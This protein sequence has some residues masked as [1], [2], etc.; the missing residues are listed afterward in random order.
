MV[1]DIQPGETEESIVTDLEYRFASPERMKSCLVQCFIEL[2]R[3]EY[4]INIILLDAAIYDRNEMNNKI[5]KSD[6][7]DQ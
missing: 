5:N 6:V 4:I 3:L 1:N 7:G 2:R